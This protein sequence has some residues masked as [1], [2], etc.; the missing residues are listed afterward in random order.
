[1]EIT[2]ENIKAYVKYLSG[3]GLDITVHR[4]KPVNASEFFA[5]LNVH[6]NPYCL[7]V[8]SKKQAWDKCISCQKNVMK[9]AGLGI[10]FEGMCYAGVWEYVFPMSEAGFLCVS[11]YR[12][13]EKKA[14]ARMEKLCE[15][16]GHDKNELKN[17]YEKYLNPDIPDF[18]FVKTLIYPL[19]A[20]FSLYYKNSPEAARK[21]IFETNADYIYS[22][23]LWYIKNNF[24]DKITLEKLC[25]FCHCSPSYISHIFK[26]A[27]GKS[28]NAFTNELRLKEA[29]D[30]LSKEDMS[31][32]D[33][34]LAVGF[35]DTNYFSNLFKKA[36]GVSPSEY[37]K[38]KRSNR[39]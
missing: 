4:D 7:L 32:T 21:G 35:S 37:K 39:K 9:E 10:P 19:L 29:A 34:A 38:T 31:V 11:G 17:A 27:S 13:D 5:D 14:Q 26:T 1:M 30:I 2:D 33:T 15:K 23:A 16:Y 22:H 20:M 8:K 6:S 28:I 12:K 25:A 3:L 36:Y 18:H 24:S